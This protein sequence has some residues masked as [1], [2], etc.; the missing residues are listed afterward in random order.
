MADLEEVPWVRDWSPAQIWGPS[1]LFLLQ[2]V[3][4]QSFLTWPCRPLLGA[5]PSSHF[6]IGLAAARQASA[7]F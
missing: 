1:F 3:Q 5:Q 2:P 4:G 7:Y 6:L